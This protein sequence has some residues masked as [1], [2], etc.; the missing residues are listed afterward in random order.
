[1]LKLNKCSKPITEAKLIYKCPKHF[2]RFGKSC[3][4]LSNKTLTWQESFFECKYLAKGS[5][6]AVL[7]K[8]WNDLSAQQF[9]KNNEK[10]TNERWIGGIYDWWRNEWKWANSG[11]K[12][13]NYQLNNIV[14][15]MNPP[16]NYWQCLT[17]NPKNN[18]KWNIQSCLKENYYICQTKFQPMCTSDKN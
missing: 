1:M 4:Y 16:Q 5:K 18:F 14:N 8:N 3:Y 13:S 11:H 6:L 2:S 15:S 9:L 7:A 17:I 12:I 10:E